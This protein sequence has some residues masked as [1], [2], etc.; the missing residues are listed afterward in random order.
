MRRL[1]AIHLA[2]AAPL[3][4]L[5]IWFGVIDST[6]FGEARCA[7]CGVEDYVIAAHVA[8]A[9]CLTALVWFISPGRVTTVA[10]TAAALFVAASLLW[11]P[12]FAVLRL[13][14]R[15]RLAAAHPRRGDLVGAERGGAVAQAIRRRHRV[16]APPRGGLA[17]LGRASAG[18]LRLGLGRSG[19]VDRVLSRAPFTLIGMD[20]DGPQIGYKALPSGAPVHTSDGEQLGTV[21][22][23][24]DNARE[25]IFDGIVVS[26]PDGRRFVDAP[27][28]ARITERR[29]TL[30]IDASEARE[31][32][33]YGGRRAAI[34][35]RAQRA[36]RRWKRRLSR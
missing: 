12:L 7:S 25:H 17:R 34:Q 23:V 2:C 16:A 26:T 15:G 33:E 10:L 31:L 22:R 11:H 28:V 32:P 21:H 8:A 3:V 9:A 14:G 20:D 18:P 13:R 29:V 27:E 36:G 24:L 1:A 4:A 35:T 30:T 19:R 6:P 5:A